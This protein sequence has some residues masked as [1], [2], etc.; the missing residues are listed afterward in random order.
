MY[1]PLVEDVRL[2]SQD[3]ATQLTLSDRVVPLL[4]EFRRP[5]RNHS[6]DGV[7]GTPGGAVRQASAE[8]PEDLCEATAPLWQGLAALDV[9]LHTSDRVVQD[10]AKRDPL[11]RRLQTVPRVG[12][13]IVTIFGAT[14]IDPHRF[15]SGRAVGAASPS[16]ETGRLAGHSRW[17]QAHYSTARATA[18]FNNGRDHFAASP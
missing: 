5:R 13:I 4:R 14:I 12:P 11:L 8:L 6:P 1:F 9:C 16:T 10:K 15:A 7:P 3:V 17:R 2:H 18:P